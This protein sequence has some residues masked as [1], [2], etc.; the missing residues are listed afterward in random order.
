[1]L[2]VSLGANDPDDPA[3]FRRRVELIVRGRACVAWLSIPHRPRLNRVLASTPGVTV[4]PLRGVHR[5]DGIHPDRAG[6]RLLASR[7]RRAC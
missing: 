3:P 4:V 5:T 7:F 6:Y 1:M 2:Y